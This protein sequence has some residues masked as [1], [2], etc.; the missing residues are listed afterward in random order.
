MDMLRFHKF[1]I[2]KNCMLHEAYAMVDV[3]CPQH[4]C[5]NTLFGVRLSLG[6]AWMTDFG[7]PDKKEHFDWLIKYSPLHNVKPRNDVQY[8]A[9]L[10][11]TG[12]HDDRVV[13]LHSL[14]L[15]A[16]LQYQLGKQANQVRTRLGGVALF[17]VAE[18]SLPNYEMSPQCRVSLLITV[19]FTC[20]R[21]LAPPVFRPIPC[22]LVW[23]SRRAMAPVNQRTSALLRWQT[24][25]AFWPP[26]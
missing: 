2:G 16:E 6:H 24:S 4:H 18:M 17:C 13:P 1:T 9:M 19:H 12:D 25:L 7:D 15:I 8:P 23:K 26:P 20:L 3:C 11:L 21:Y 10:I 14:K 5:Q 22:W